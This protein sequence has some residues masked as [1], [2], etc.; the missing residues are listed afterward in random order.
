MIR[1]S[2]L[3]RPRQAFTLIELLVVIAII[4]LLISILL[5]ALAEARYVAAQ[6]KGQVAAREQNNGYLVYANDHQGEVLQ[7]FTHYSAGHVVEG[8]RPNHHGY[9]LEGWIVKRYTWRLMEWMD[10]NFDAIQH[11]PELLALM[12]QRPEAIPQTPANHGG[13][14]VVNDGAAA[15]KFEA[16]FS[17]HPSLG[18]NTVYL[19]GDYEYGGEQAI[20]GRVANWRTVGRVILRNM[21]DV[22]FSDKMISF[23][24]AR[25]VLIQNTGP[26]QIVP[27]FF[28]ACAPI[29]PS[30]SHSA[31]A[32]ASAENGSTPNGW[33]AVVRADPRGTY[34][35]WFNNPSITD[36][37]G[38]FGNIDYRWKDRAMVTHLDGHVTL[39]RIDE[40]NDMRQW[41]NWATTWNQQIT[42]I[43]QRLN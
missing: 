10:Y 40:L 12:R 15:N 5:P 4:V 31:N 27:G 28:R 2:H 39:Q 33:M 18:M 13:A 6:V 9:Y 23:A 35:L 14:R 3:L 34:N 32:G 29:T 16:V 20:R 36:R 37:T 25:G 7:G 17:A 8:M 30:P 24:S 19:G 42:N 22:R 43:N 26:R 1:P 38:R 41:C 21:N 11:D